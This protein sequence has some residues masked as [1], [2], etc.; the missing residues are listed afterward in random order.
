VPDPAKPTL[1]DRLRVAF[2]KPEPAGKPKPPAKKLSAEELQTAV[3]RADDK[4]RLIGLMAAPFAAIIGILVTSDLIS[5]DPPAFKDG[6]ADKLHVSVSLYHD[7]TLVLLALAVAMLAFAWF[8]KRLYLGMVLAL[9][10]LAIFNLH[11]WGFGVPFIL[12][13]AWYL[14]RAYRLQ[15]DLREATGGKQSGFRSRD[16]GASSTLGRPASNK[17]YTQPSSRSRS[18][19]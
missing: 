6:R 16:G 5:H 7:L 2:L 19:N 12:A 15:R 18:A 3:K 13:G 4:E 17:R 1:I 9:F 10:G 11:Y 8:R 14:V